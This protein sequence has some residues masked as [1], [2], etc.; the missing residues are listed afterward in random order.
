MRCRGAIGV[1]QLDRVPDLNALRRRFI[2]EGVWVRPFA[3][4]VYLMPPLV[5]D[6]EDLA[7]LT[8]AVC[9]VVSEWSRAA[10]ARG[11]DVRSLIDQ[12]DRPDPHQRLSSLTEAPFRHGRDRLLGGEEVL[13]QDPLREPRFF[14][15]KIASALRPVEP[16]PWPAPHQPGPQR[17]D[18]ENLLRRGRRQRIGRKTMGEGAPPL[19][20]ADAVR[21]ARLQHEG[22]HV[23]GQLL[24]VGA[25]RV[26]LVEARQDLPEERARPAGYWR[27]RRGDSSR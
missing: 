25:M 22:M 12:P 27:S 5:I 24:H 2:E 6:A 21:Q 4:V 3:D 11:L 20:R 8:A 26:W 9:R 14:R 13:G 19:L 10:D 7:T 1:V 17:P 16:P 18:A 15:R 23:V